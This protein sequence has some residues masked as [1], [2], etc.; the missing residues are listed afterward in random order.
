MTGTSDGISTG[1]NM[2]IF[3]FEIIFTSAEIYGEIVATEPLLYIILYILQPLTLPNQVSTEYAHRE[4]EKFEKTATFIPQE[5]KLERFTT[6][7][8]AYTSRN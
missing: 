5:I 2:C 6:L 1:Y 7:N 4:L 3:L 8:D